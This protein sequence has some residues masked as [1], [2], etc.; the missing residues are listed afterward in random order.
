MDG[1]AETNLGIS[2]V[3]SDVLSATF[4]DVPRSLMLV[5]CFVELRHACLHTSKP[6]DRPRWPQA[7]QM[8]VLYCSLLAEPVTVDNIHLMTPQNSV[9]CL[10]FSN[11]R[12]LPKSIARTIPIKRQA[13]NSSV[14]TIPIDR[15][16]RHSPVGALAY[17]DASCPRQNGNNTD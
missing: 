15:Q 9:L 13:P 7:P 17:C 6:V 4:G 3:H 11:N 10:Q 8:V 1:L 5:T 12:K 14:Q 16:R 2:R